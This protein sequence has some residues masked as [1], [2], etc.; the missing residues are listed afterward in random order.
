MP[1]SSSLSASS[2]LVGGLRATAGSL[3]ASKGRVLVSVV[4]IA[5]GVALGYAVQL[6]NRVAV[7]EFTQAVQ[8]LSGAADLAIRGPRGGFDERVFA[9]VARL[10]E[11]A[12]ASPVVEVDARIPGRDDALRLLGLDAFRAGLVQPGLVPDAAESLDTLRDDAIFLNAAAMD[13]LGARA[14][15]FVPVQVGTRVIRLRVAG[16]VRAEGHAQRLAVMDI[17]GAQ[18]RLARMGRLSRIELRA[19][20]GA[21]IA[22][23]ERRIAA[24][25]PAGVAVERPAAVIESTVRLSRAYRV[26]LNVLALVA[27]F[28]GGLLVFSTQALAVVRRRSHLALLR[29]LGMTRGGLVGLLLL[30]A[31]AIGAIGAFV[32]LLGGYGLAQLVLGVVGPDLGSGFFRGVAARATFEAAPAALFFALGVAT[33]LLGSLAAAG[34]AARTE[35]AQALKAGDEQRAFGRLT[36]VW[37]GITLIALGAV[38][39]AAPPV[40]GLPVFGYVAIGCLLVGTILL[41]ARIARAAFHRIPVLQAPPL[42]LA[43]LQLR[44]APGQATV[45]LAAIVASVSLLVSMA[46]MVA[47]FRQS[48]DDWLEHV[49]PADFYLRAG[50][51]GDTAY[52]PPDVQRA[53]AALPGVK[54][55]EFLRSERL[56]LDPERPQIVLLARSI[57]T[58]TAA[59]RLPLVRSAPAQAGD[60]KGGE[61][62]R[63]PPAWVSETAADVYGFAAGQEIE[64]P[65]A[66]RRVRFRVVGVWRDYARQQGAV[67]INRA[68]YAELTGD[69]DANDA[70][71]YLAPGASAESVA[72]ALRERVPGASEL[73]TALPSEIRARSLAI[74]DRTFAVTYALEAAALVIG[75]M[76]LSSSFGALVLARRREFGM[77][78]HLGV[79]RMQIGTMLAAEGAIVSAL[80]L[81]V[82]TALGWIISL[83][84]IHVVN[85]QSFHWSMDL[86]LPWMP[87]AAFTAAMLLLAS[88]TALASGRQAMGG[89]VVR[90]VK[91]DW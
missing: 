71:I 63:L 36:P 32:G 20:P 30:E 66:G 85:R 74:F 64:L 54:A 81:A 7:N 26:N 45:S 43:V 51:T 28:T 65:I 27:L 44:G 59:L 15:D 86:H 75:L 89:D 84:L 79:T 16:S 9:D 10:P 42:R 21:D 31:A 90:A 49:L 69:R 35:P 50:R 57:D 2:P 73:E 56:L 78:R 4:A 25:L 72:R 47:S 88:A 48:L 70:A 40:S 22:A 24:L 38:L 17:A 6:V 23:L 91:E 52:L 11:I 87:L 58:A 53:I 33:A 5:L 14:G 77:L 12:A 80:G 39:T 55:V 62:D 18:W 67:V 29:V 61:N 37:P 19:H 13:W 41:M 3:A 68:L 34:E 8:T 60:E 83:I 76:G 46:I 82:G 1:R